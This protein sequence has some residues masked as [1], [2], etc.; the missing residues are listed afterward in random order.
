RIDRRRKLPV[1]TLLLALGVD[2][3]TILATF[4]DEILYRRAGNGWRTGFRP[5]HYKGQTLITDLIDANSGETLAEAGTKLTPKLVKRLEEQGLT[6]LY[7]SSE[8]L[9]GRYLARDLIDESTGLVHAEAGAE[10]TGEMTKRL[11]EAGVETI[12]V[13]DIDHLTIGPYIRNTLAL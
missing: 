3:E 5:E 12:P 10:L 7:F 2:P 8:S 6:D 13:L 1:T 11:V 9:V 4:Y